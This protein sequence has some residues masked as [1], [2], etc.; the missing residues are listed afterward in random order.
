MMNYYNWSQEMLTVTYNSL[1]T[2]SSLLLG[3]VSLDRWNNK[4]KGYQY[5]NLFYQVASPN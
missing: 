3:K 5:Q 1:T 2:N 4:K